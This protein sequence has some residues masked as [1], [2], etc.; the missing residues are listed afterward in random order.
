M[1]NRHIIVKSQ[2]VGF[3]L[4]TLNDIERLQIARF[5]FFFKKKVS[6][7]SKKALPN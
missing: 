6:I 4:T 3:F 7:I 5:Y 2:G 1:V